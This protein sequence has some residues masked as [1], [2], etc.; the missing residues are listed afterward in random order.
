MTSLLFSLGL[1]WWHLG[2]TQEI[3]TLPKERAGETRCIDSKLL[4][5]MHTLVCLR[6]I[7][8]RYITFMTKKTCT[9]A[10]P[11]MIHLLFIGEDIL[12]GLVEHGLQEGLVPEHVEQ[13][14]IHLVTNRTPASGRRDNILSFAGQATRWQGTDCGRTPTHHTGGPCMTQRYP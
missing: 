4:T 8:F 9:I 12:Q 7:Q 13:T 1:F 11:P 14:T 5:M 10:I 6:R 2:P 3:D